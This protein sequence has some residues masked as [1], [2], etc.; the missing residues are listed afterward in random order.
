MDDAG[1]SPKLL[2]VPFTPVA[3]T[4][5]ENTSF[6]D[7]P[8]GVPIVSSPSKKLAGCVSVMTYVPGR[9]FGNEYAPDESVSTAIGVIAPRS[10]V[11]VS[12]TVAF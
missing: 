4:M 8:P 9:R 11:P 10:L 3:S 5:F 6:A 1:S 2:A 12:V 7:V